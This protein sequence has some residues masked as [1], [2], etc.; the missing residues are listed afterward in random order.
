[1]QAYLWCL[2]FGL[3]LS[4]TG[5]GEMHFESAYQ[6]LKNMHFESDHDHTCRE[7]AY[8]Y[9][10]QYALLLCIF[11]SIYCC[12]YQSAYSCMHFEGEYERNTYES[13]Y[14]TVDI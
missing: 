5:Q 1:M 2:V 13:A 8:W 4:A 7:S 14:R 6:P 10:A 9:A 3:L 12:A 11:Y